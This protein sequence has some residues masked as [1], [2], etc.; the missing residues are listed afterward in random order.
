MATVAGRGRGAFMSATFTELAAPNVSPEKEPETVREV[1]EWTNLHPL[2]WF[3]P[4]LI[5]QEG[6]HVLHGHEESFKTMFML[7]LH[8]ALTTGRPFLAWKTEG[9]LRTGIA[10]LEMKMPMSGS[11][12]RNF[13]R[14]GA[15]PD[16]YFLPESARRK[17]LSGKSA[18]DR[19]NVIVEWAKGKGLDFVSIDSLAKLFPAGHDPSRQDLASDVFSHIQL[20]PTTLIL[21]H[22][23]KPQESKGGGSVGNAEIVGSGRMAQEPDVVHQV[24]RPDKRAPMVE[25]T[26]GKMRE[27]VKAELLEIYFDRVDF[28][29]HPYHPFLHLLPATQQELIQ[30]AE[31]R[32]GWKERRSREYI[33][34]LLKLPGTETEQGAANE[35]KLVFSTLTISELGPALER[36]RASEE[37][38]SP[39]AAASKSPGT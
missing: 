29:L 2:R 19:I 31:R 34:S 12:F 36:Q 17:V 10:E 25:L 5:I 32:Y 18:S 21:A 39:A 28:R 13:C 15:I 30:E 23:R 14:T 4:N 3:M 16:I 9:G 22:D 1:I 11:R 7:Q 24:I 38:E 26:C 6:I 37:E 35:S 33:Q 20:L 8:E 27:G